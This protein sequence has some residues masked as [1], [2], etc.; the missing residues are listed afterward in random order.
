MSTYGTLLGFGGA[1]YFYFLF[2]K[3]P[4]GPLVFFWGA[5]VGHKAVV[6]W[7]G[8]FPPEHRSLQVVE[9]SRGHPASS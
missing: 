8:G 2:S 6:T 5:F 7:P 1:L 4:F 3:C 9:K